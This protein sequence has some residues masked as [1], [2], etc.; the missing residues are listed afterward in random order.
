MGRGAGQKSSEVSLKGEIPEPGVVRNAA[1]WEI[2]PH[3]PNLR[4]IML[5][6]CSI[7]HLVT[8]QFCCLNHQSIVQYVF[9][10]H[11]ENAARF[12]PAEF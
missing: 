5:V 10:E 2:V 12:Y 7:L 9:N 8:G 1:P 11:S 4:T 3:K 6:F